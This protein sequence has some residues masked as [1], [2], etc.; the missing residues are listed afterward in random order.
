MVGGAEQRSA[1]HGAALP[2]SYVEAT[3]LWGLCNEQST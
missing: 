3:G 1:N 2:N